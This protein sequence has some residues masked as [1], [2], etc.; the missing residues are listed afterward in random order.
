MANPDAF[1]SILFKI[2]QYKTEFRYVER[3]LFYFVASKLSGVNAAIIIF[4]FV[5]YCIVFCVRIVF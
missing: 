2:D 1:N 4:V 5:L 3:S